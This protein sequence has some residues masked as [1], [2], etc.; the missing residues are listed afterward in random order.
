[1]PSSPAGTNRR[2]HERLEFR[3]AVTAIVGTPGAFHCLRCQT[4]DVSFE[5]AR[6]VCF[7]SIPRQPLYLRILMPGLSERFVEAEIVNE[8]AYSDLRFGGGAKSR[9]I[10]GVRFRRIVVDESLLNELR[11]AATP[12]P[13]AE[14]RS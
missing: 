3:T 2:R 13:Q 8:R 4:D 1:M 9:Y 5:G 10:Y 7:E 11:S 12:R 6:L 14:D